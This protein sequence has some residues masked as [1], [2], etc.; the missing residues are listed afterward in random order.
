MKTVVEGKVEGKK[1]EQDDSNDIDGW[2]PKKRCTGVT[3]IGCTLKSRDRLTIFGLPKFFRV[4]SREE[5]MPAQKKGDA[6]TG[7]AMFVFV[8]LFSTAI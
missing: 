3:L 5:R 1:K 7:L 4:L 2:T 6:R 8:C